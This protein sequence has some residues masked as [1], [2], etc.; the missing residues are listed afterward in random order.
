LQ[1]KIYLTHPDSCYQIITT[2]VISFE[3]PE[4]T[5]L[6]VFFEALSDDENTVRHIKLPN[7]NVEVETGPVRATISN[8]DYLPIGYFMRGVKAGSKVSFSLRFENGGDIRVKNLS[9]HSATDTLACEFEKGVV[10]VNPSLNSVSLN[11]KEIFPHREGYSK[12]KA[13]EV[14]R[15]KVPSKYISQYEQAMALND[16]QPLSNPESVTVLE[17]N[18]LFLLAEPTVRGK[19]TRPATVLTTTSSEVGSSSTTATSTD[20]P[21]ATITDTLTSLDAIPTSAKPSSTKFGAPIPSYHPTMIPASTLSFTPACKDVKNKFELEPGT[22]VGCWYVTRAKGNSSIFKKRC[23]KATSQGPSIVSNF[24]PRSCNTC[25]CQD[26]KASFRLLGS[27]SKNPVNCGWTLKKPE[28]TRHRCSSL[29][30]QFIIVSDI[31][32]RACGLC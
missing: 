16:G 8:I 18:A 31:C 23:S 22:M 17:R 20:V 24:C 9:V 12:L 19:P 14:D 6:T 2:T 1:I 15:G 32:P 4:E 7:I 5:D 26:S 13:S 27:T 21:P 25:E 10:L 29:S 28:K 11:L 30:T 3:L